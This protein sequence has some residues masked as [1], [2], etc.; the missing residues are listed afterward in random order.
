MLVVLPVKNV[1]W[2]Y[3]QYSTE[4]TNT[5]WEKKKKIQEK[6]QKKVLWQTLPSIKWASSLLINSGQ[7][8]SK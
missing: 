2:F 7:K 4:E 8:N 3:L 1:D 6:S 5:V